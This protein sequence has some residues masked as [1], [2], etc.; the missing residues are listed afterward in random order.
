MARQSAFV[1]PAAGFNMQTHVILRLIAG[2]AGA[3][4]FALL[5]PAAFAHEDL[6]LQI[7]NVT[8]Q[9]ER[10]PKNPD[11]HLRRGELHRL[12]QEFDAALADYERAAQLTNNP[13][14]VDY[15]RGRLFHEA[16]WTQSARFFLDRFLARQTNHRDALIVRARV[17][18][19]LGEREAAAADYA[20]A[21]RL[22][23]EPR[24]ELFI[25]HA[26]VLTT[27]AGEHLAEALASLDL[28]M[29]KLGPLVTL[30][31]FAIDIEVRRT[32]YDGA[33]GRLDKIMAQSPRKETWLARKGE[34]LQQA[35]RTNDARVAFKTALTAIANLSPTRRQV[36][37]MQELEKRLQDVLAGKAEA[38]AAGA[39]SATKPN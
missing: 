10:D 34:I 28:G 29:K 30:Q 37:A 23:T 39:R 8:A 27:D 38:N 19:R 31:L 25:E 35:G 32:N 1:Y 11:L 6:L 20:A 17:L 21:L 33:L 9:L 36:P 26:Q 4:C 16:N 5:P 7:Q 15:A 18:A 13:V 12:H 2:L 3:L 22:T 24:P 14:V